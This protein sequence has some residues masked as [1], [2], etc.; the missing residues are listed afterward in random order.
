MLFIS[1]T[2]SFAHETACGDASNAYFQASPLPPELQV[3]ARAP[4]GFGMYLNRKFDGA[5][6]FRACDVFFRTKRPVCGHPIAGR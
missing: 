6:P 1:L 3:L 5:P 4:A 2:V